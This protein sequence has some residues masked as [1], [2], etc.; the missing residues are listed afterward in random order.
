MDTHSVQP[1]SRIRFGV[2]N[3]P[4]TRFTDGDYYWS[5]VV[6]KA[7]RVWR[8]KPQHGRKV[9]ENDS[10]TDQIA[11]SSISKRELPKKENICG[12]G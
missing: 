3:F 12:L 1:W 2:Q 9:W 7:E 8:T 11:I 6:P 4:A 5:L 10:D